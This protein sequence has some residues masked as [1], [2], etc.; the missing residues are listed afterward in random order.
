MQAS[1]IS[2]PILSTPHRAPSFYPLLSFRPSS[3]LFFGL[4]SC[5]LH[6]SLLFV[7]L[8]FTIS[9]RHRALAIP[10]SL[11]ML[12]SFKLVGGRCSS[13]AVYRSPLSALADS[14]LPDARLS[15]F[16][17]RGSLLAT[18]YS[19]LVDRVSRALLV[20]SCLLPRA[21]CL[22]QLAR[23]P[24]RSDLTVRMMFSCLKCWYVFLHI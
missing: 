11:S 14:P 12:A 7:A 24:K 23:C 3:I 22:L 4:L 15:S 20:A 16:G 6:S 8:L 19:S 18:R 13:L 10:K 17:V 21:R 1:A 9:A 2:R 5:L